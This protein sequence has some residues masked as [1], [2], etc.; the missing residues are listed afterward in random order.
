MDNLAACEDFFITVLESHI[1]SA[2]MTLF[3]MSKLD[4]RPC[5]DFFPAASDCLD[6]SKR[7]NVLLLA[8]EA[9]VD[10]FIDISV[11]I[12]PEDESTSTSTATSS[13]L[14]SSATPTIEDDAVDADVDFSTATSTT[15][16]DHKFAYACDLLS[17]GLLLLELID[18][19]R[20]GDG[21][22]IIRVWRYMFVIFKATNCKNYAIEGFTLLMQKMYLF[23]PRMAAQLEWS[24]TVN[25]HGRGGK[26]IPAD[27]YM[28]HLNRECKGILSGMYSN[29]T[30]KSVT[31][32]SRAL[33]PL[34]STMLAFDLQNKVPF[35]SG[36]HHRKSTITDKKKI[37]KQLRDSKVF[38][39]RP[40]RFHKSF[41]KH[42]QNVM[43]KLK[44]VKLKKWMKQKAQDILKYH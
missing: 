26:N 32:V 14:A 27:L 16:K 10:K 11:P 12:L 13:I 41:P 19:V 24:R 8:V 39:K 17:N 9:L 5:G 30:E 29:V 43:L 40:K 3:K 25:V 18:A 42:S 6:A 7:V 22:R 37:I 1:L 34:H 44:P 4:D 15:E 23:S 28:E 33:K 20:E 31:R 2:A 21:K 35:D 36:V 38:I